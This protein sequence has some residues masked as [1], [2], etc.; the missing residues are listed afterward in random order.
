M[1]DERLRLVVD[2]LGR[3]GPRLAAGLTDESVLLV[4]MNDELRR[5]VD[6]DSCGER[7]RAGLRMK[8]RMERPSLGVGEGARFLDVMLGEAALFDAMRRL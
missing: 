8:E 3:P 6:L 4:S 7:K 2:P 5:L 1:D